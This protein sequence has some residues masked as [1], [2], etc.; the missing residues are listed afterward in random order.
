MRETDV[1]ISD[2]VEKVGLVTLINVILDL[3][4]R[5]IFVKRD[6]NETATAEP[7]NI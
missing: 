4:L 7:D 5:Q 6:Q 1:V 3:T 2:R